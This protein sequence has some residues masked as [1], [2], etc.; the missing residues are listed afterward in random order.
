[1]FQEL[2]QVLE[3]LGRSVG[4]AGGEQGGE[5]RVQS[6]PGTILLVVMLMLLLVGVL[7]LLLVVGTPGLTHVDL[8]LACPYLAL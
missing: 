2:E 7:L 1:V 6:L 5:V 4:G 3:P 8:A